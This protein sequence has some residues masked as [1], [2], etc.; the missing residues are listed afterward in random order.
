MWKSKFTDV[1]EQG[2]VGKQ[3]P[4][5]FYGFPGT[6]VS[7]EAKKKRPPPTMESKSSK[8]NSRWTDGGGQLAPAIAHRRLAAARDRT[9]KQK[10]TQCLT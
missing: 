3:K 1:R 7:R 10:N 8:L 4:I 6:K 2:N 9:Q 5:I